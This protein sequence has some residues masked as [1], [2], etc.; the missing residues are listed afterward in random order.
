MP[1]KLDGNRACSRKLCQYC[2]RILCRNQISALFLNLAESD[3]DSNADFYRELGSKDKEIKAGPES[4]EDDLLNER[5]DIET[6]IYRWVIPQCIRESLLTTALAKKNSF[7]QKLSSGILI[8]LAIILEL[9]IV[10]QNIR[11]RV[12]GDVAIITS[13]PLKLKP[14]LDHSKC[15]LQVIYLIIMNLSC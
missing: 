1:R 2:P 12:V 4:N 9:R 13:L 11:L 8:L 3:W 10:L 6:M 5:K 15:C 14:P 7:L